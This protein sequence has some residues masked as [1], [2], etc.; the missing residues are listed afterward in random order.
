MVP[1]SVYPDIDP[2]IGIPDIL[3]VVG[4]FP[5]SGYPIS[6]DRVC[7]DI[8]IPDIGTNIGIYRYRDH[9]SRYRVIE[10]PD[11]DVS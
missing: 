7:P 1:I 9:M 4:T 2:D 3:L 11:I 8:R 6:D 10:F 5:I